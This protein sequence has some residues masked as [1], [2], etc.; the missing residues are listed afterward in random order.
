MTAPTTPYCTPQLASLLSLNM[1]KGRTPTALSPVD[2]ATWTQLIT[3]TDSMLEG[4][5]HSIGYKIPFLELSGETWPTFQTTMLQYASAMGAMAMASGY[6]LSPA[7]Q[8]VAGRTQGERNAYAVLIE[9]FRLEVRKHGFRFR[10]QYYNGTKAEKNL[11]TVY[12]PQTDFMKDRWDPTRYELFRAYTDRMVEVFDD[13]AD[14]QIA[15]D[16][17]Y[18]DR[19]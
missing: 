19:A 3:W 4:D 2:P 16:Y 1:F 18:L 17:V 9:N 15:W 5:F 12:G 10:A 7:P 14:Y 13:M 8:L 11:A 6:I